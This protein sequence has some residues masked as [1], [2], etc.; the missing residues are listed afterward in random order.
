MGLFEGRDGKNFFEEGREVRGGLATERE[1]ETVAEQSETRGYI[2]CSCS[3]GG[4][5]GHTLHT[6][7]RDARGAEVRPPGLGGIYVRDPADTRCL[8]GTPAPRPTSG[9]GTVRAR[10]SK[11]R[12]DR[13][14]RIAAVIGTCLTYGNVVLTKKTYTWCACASSFLSH[15]FS[16]S[17]ILR[18]L[19][20]CLCVA[21]DIQMSTTQ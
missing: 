21:T 14:R 3:I 18:P 12:S 10:R 5:L 19:G 20:S 8:V 6:A 7:V 13:H 17:P 1:R 11:R 16:I 15:P 2:L 9:P 4:G